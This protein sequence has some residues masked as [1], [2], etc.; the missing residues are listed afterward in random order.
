M[1]VGKPLFVLEEPLSPADLKTYKAA[2]ND[3]QG[4]ILKSHGRDAALHVFL[5]FKTRRQRE[6][7]QFL[8]EFADKIVVSAIGQED[9]KASHKRGKS[10]LFATVSLS[11]KGYQYLGFRR[12]HLKE[13]GF[14]EEFLRGMQ[15]AAN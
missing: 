5:T 9:Q 13:K 6:A 15:R 3:L 8:G 10:E 2:L 14:T 7:R 1:P 4:N 11:A 12:K